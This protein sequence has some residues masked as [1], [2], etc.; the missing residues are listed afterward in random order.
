MHFFSALELNFH[1]CE[2][3][4]FFFFLKQFT[5]TICKRE[6]GTTPS[7]QNMN[8]SHLCSR[9]RAAVM[10]AQQASVHYIDFLLDLLFFFFF[11]F[12]N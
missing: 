9:W 5:T 12:L 8:T 3:L 7:P 1:N 6:S 4:K 10:F 11:A 2:W